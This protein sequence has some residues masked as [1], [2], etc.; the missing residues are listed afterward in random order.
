MPRGR[1]AWR[2]DSLEPWQR[3]DGATVCP[4]GHAWIRE[5]VDLG[6]GGPRCALCRRE[7]V[8]ARTYNLAADEYDAI[9][10]A[11]GNACAICRKPFIE[12][13]RRLHVDH[14]HRSLL[15]RGLL[16]DGCNRR[17]IG[18]HRDPAIFEAAAVY[19]RNPPAV[20]VVGERFAPKP[21]RKR[22]ARREA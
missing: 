12:G 17:V 8:I 21:K 5:N 11:Q 13:G 18:R 1:A 3:A 10:E 6:S 9:L 15:V 19:L 7:Q 22:K 2:S 20:A 4:R 16:C 14:D